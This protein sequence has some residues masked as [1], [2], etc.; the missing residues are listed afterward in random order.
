MEISSRQPRE[1]FTWALTIQDEKLREEALLRA[2]G[3]VTGENLSDL[4]ENSNLPEAKR[5]WLLEIHQGTLK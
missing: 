2:A 1:S 4:I 5:A 3:S